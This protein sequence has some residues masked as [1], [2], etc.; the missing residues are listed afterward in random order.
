MDGKVKNGKF[1]LERDSMGEIQVPAEKYWGAQTQRSTHY[2]N[3]GLDFIP[4]EVIRAL[5]V[6][7]KASALANQESGRLKPELATAICQA[8]VSLAAASGWAATYSS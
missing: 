8:A 5:A 1:R 6:I 7:K 3:I 4:E 2:F